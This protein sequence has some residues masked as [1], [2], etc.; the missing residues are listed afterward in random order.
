MQT[1]LSLIRNA[2]GGFCAVLACVAV[3]PAQ[4][5]PAAAESMLLAEATGLRLP[6]ANDLS[7]RDQA[8]YPDHADLYDRSPRRSPYTDARRL[9]LADTEARSHVQYSLGENWSTQMATAA[10]DP[11]DPLVRHTLHGQ[12]QRSLPGG[13]DVG[14]GLRRNDFLNAA[15]NA[16]SLS[17]EGQWGDLRGGY[18]LMSGLPDGVSTES[19]RFQL[20]YQYG[21]RSSFGLSYTNGRD[22]D[23][24]AATRGLAATAIDNWSLGGQHQL[25]PAWALTYDVVHG[26]QNSLTPRQGLR[27]GLRHNF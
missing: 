25:A 20:S 3:G 5:Q 13:W 7:A 4:A 9:G 1:I 8:L 27:L 6:R 23:Y 17:A 18:T 10:A 16:L 24:Q 11:G 26:T 12:L 14:L 2:I 19:H 22:I 15:T 21:E